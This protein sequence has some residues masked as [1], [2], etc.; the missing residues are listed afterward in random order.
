MNAPIAL[1]CFNRPSHLKQTIKNLLENRIAKE[2][3]LF[4]FSDGP[5]SN[6][7]GELKLVNE[8]R[9]Y[10]YTIEGF[11][12]IQV[13]EEPQNKGLA[14]SIIEGLSKLFLDYEKLIVLEDDILV[15]NNF[16]VF[17]NDSLNRY[18]HHETIFSVS[19]YS[20]QLEELNAAGDLNLVKR[21][22]SWGW[23]TWRKNWNAVD[24]EVKEYKTFVSNK[25]AQKEFLN[26][27]KDQLAMLYKQQRGLI[28][29]WAI[30]WTFHHF[31]HKG[32]CLVPKYSKV[33][34][35]G[36]DGTGTNFKNATN[37]FT[38]ELSNK[39]IEWPKSI[40]NHEKIN[41]FI[42]NKFAPSS[43]RKVINFLKFKIWT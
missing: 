2:T 41:K 16:L 17:M 39:E 5:K 26:A 20:F 13:I 33:K 7:A 28:D 4:I 42:K 31:V 43:F 8:V 30:R 35:I 12:S 36:T 23:G 29:S 22:S 34:N 19:G 14:V 9:K 37:K 27:G 1:F 21:A 24:W 40:E 11:Q 10:I 3:E 25:V 38:T 15:S 6:E 18:E 32:Y